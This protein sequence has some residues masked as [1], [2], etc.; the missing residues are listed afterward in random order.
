MTAHHALLNRRTF[1]AAAIATLVV[2]IVSA[3]GPPSQPAPA[4]RP[5]IPVKVDVALSRWQS[6][7][8]IS[9]LPFALWVQLGAANNPSFGN[10]SL[11][12]GID[13]PIGTTTETR[14]NANQGQ[15]GGAS[16]TRPEYKNIGTSIDCNVTDM[17]EG[18]Y[19]VF[20]NLVDSSIFSPDADRSAAL[21]AKGLAP[22]RPAVPKVTD[23]SAFRTFSFSN[24]L[25][26]RDGQ[27][28][29]FATATDKITGEVLKV[30]V[31]ITLAK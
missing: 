9:S 7:K 23:P 30:T 10:A 13:V 6:D 2:G 16:T 18:R 5:V 22:S 19:L 31:T 11:R 4:P 26:M 29:E 21:A 20:V 28:L 3:Q 15:S 24:R 27:T 25:S 14:S 17:Q 1:A 8:Q 12:V